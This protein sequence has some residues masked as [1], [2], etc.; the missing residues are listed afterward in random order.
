MGG[1]ELEKE[2]KTFFVSYFGF[3]KLNTMDTRWEMMMN[4]SN[5]QVNQFISRSEWEKNDRYR[6]TAGRQ[7]TH[8]LL[9]SEIDAF[10][11][12]LFDSHCNSID[13]FIIFSK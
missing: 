8:H 9:V 2:I 3:V 4:E 1:G 11:L 13:D 6:M 12:S 5:T 7:A 10:S